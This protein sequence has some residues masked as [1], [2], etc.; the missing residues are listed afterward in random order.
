R[1]STL[2]YVVDDLRQKDAIYTDLKFFET[3]F[4]GVLPFEI[5]IDTKKPGGAL[6]LPALYKINRLQKIIAAYPQFSEP[7]SI[8]EG[9]KFSYQGLNDDNPKYYIVP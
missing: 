5:T 6:A 3:N 7:V 4:R 2:G 9:I 1:I 8:A